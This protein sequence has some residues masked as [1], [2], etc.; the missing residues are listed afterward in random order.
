MQR[1]GALACCNLP[2][3]R[4]ASPNRVEHDCILAGAPCSKRLTHTCSSAAHPSTRLCMLGN[5]MQTHQMCMGGAWRGRAKQARPEWQSGSMGL[6]VGVH[7]SNAAVSQGMLQVHRH[8]PMGASRSGGGGGLRDRLCAAT[9][10]CWLSI[11]CAGLG[12]SVP[13]GSGG[14]GGLGSGAGISLSGCI[15]CRKHGVHVAG[16]ASQVPATMPAAHVMCRWAHT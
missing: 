13:L 7:S 2:A 11:S 14:G 8:H 10:C 5:A 4:V 1:K 3:Q 6:G 9:A 16:W 15:A 12:D